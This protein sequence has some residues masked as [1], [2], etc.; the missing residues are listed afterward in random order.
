VRDASGIAFV[1]LQAVI[2]TK[3]G[4]MAHGELRLYDRHLRLTGSGRMRSRNFFLPP[5]PP[6]PLGDISRDH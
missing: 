3:H 5:L 2:E 6:A 4:G 1:T